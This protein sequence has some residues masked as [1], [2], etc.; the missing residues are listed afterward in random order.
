MEVK[1]IAVIGAGNMGHGIARTCA[2]H[3]FEIFMT[4]KNPEA[5]EAGVRTIAEELK[6]YFVGKGRMTE[7]QSSEVLKRL[8][9]V[10]NLAEAVRSGD[11]EKRVFR[12]GPPLSNPC[13]PGQQ[14]LLSEYHRAWKRHP[15]AGQG[16][17][18]ALFQSS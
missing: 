4:D 8:H 14:Y 18:H 13:H 10:T 5:T 9:G 1:K 16:H 6:K 15:K 2:V 7:A 11:Q 17:R 3:G 12:T